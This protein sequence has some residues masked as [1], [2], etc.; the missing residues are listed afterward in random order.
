MIFHFQSVHL[1]QHSSYQ[2]LHTY[3]FPHQRTSVKTSYGRQGISSIN[4]SSCLIKL[5]I[6][7][8]KKFKDAIGI[9]NCLVATTIIWELLLIIVEK[10]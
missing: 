10:I 8:D 4:H 1:H 2:A 6:E 3:D 9:H 7:T 5:Y